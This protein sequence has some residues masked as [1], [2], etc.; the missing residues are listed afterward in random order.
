MKDLVYEIRC[1]INGRVYF[2]ST[3]SLVGR[4]SLHW[5]SLQ[6]G[7]HHC[8]ELQKDYDKY[9][10]DNF[11]LSVIEKTD[12]PRDREKFYISKNVEICYN[13]VIPTEDL[14][15]WTF[16]KKI[17]KKISDAH[18]GRVFTREEI[19]RRVKTREGYRHSK[20]TIEK[21]RKAHIG[22]K[23][24]PI[25]EETRAK[26]KASRKNRKLSPEARKNLSLAKIGSKNP[27]KRENVKLKMRESRLAYL[28]RKR[29][30][31]D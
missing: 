8:E 3:D 9:G 19:E 16:T 10:R 4:R 30:L 26:L 15:K 7:I 1:K 25:T 17:R 11:E 27:A 13:E 12:N 5:R 28:R 21:I 14:K 29:G 23:C 20:E 6:R 2:G 22:K 18:K 24:P 31:H